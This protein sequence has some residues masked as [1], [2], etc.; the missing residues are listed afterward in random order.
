LTTFATIT[1]KL[2]TFTNTS[3][4]IS[5]EILNYIGLAWQ[6]DHQSHQY[7]ETRKH[8][9]QNER[10]SWLEILTS[11]LGDKGKELIAEAFEEFNG[12]VRTSSLIEMVNSQIR[13]YLNECKGHI[14]QEHL[15]PIMFYQ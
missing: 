8:Y 4:N 3:K 5:P 6:H 15:N 10:G 9:H 14:S 12:M 1:S 13:P 11:L 2:R 7:K